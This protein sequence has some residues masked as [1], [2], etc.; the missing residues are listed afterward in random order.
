MKEKKFFLYGVLQ[1]RN[2]ALLL[3]F[4]TF[5]AGILTYNALPKQQYP[6]ISIP[7]A[8]ISAVYPGASAEDVEELVTKKIEDVAMEAD[9][10]DRVESFS[11]DNVSVVQ[12]FFQLDMPEDEQKQSKDDLRNKINDLKGTVLPADVSQLK[13]TSDIGDTAGLVLAFTSDK[14]SNEELYN[15]VDKLKTDLR[16]REGLKK[17]E[18]DG[19]A[20]QRIEIDVD[21]AKLNRLK[22]SL[23]ELSKLIPYQNNLLPAGKI[24]FNTDKI[25]VE[26]S[27]KFKDLDEIRN[28]IIGISPDTGN[29]VTLKDVATVEKTVDEDT[30]LYNYN[31]KNAILL[32]V[33]YADGINVVTTGKEVLEYIDQYK[34]KLPSDVKVNTVADLS[35]DVKASIWD[36]T[37]SVI[38]AILIV[39][40]VITL[41]MSLR[42]GTIVAVAI[43]ITMVVPFLVMKAMGIDVQFISLAALIIALGMV[44]D[45]V[46]VI[47]D[48]IQVQLDKDDSDRI[49]ACAEGV[50]GVAI[51]VL[52]S[53][54]STVC[55]FIS[56]YFMPGTTYLFTFSLPTIVISTML[57]SFV[58]SM[59]I[60]P[61][62]CFFM[63]K[64][65]VEREGK[66]SIMDRFRGVILAEYHLAAKHR[67]VT[68]AI[69]ICLVLG[70]FKLLGTLNIEFMPKGEK[71]ILDI[72]ITTTD[73]TDIRKTEKAV[74]DV[75]KVIMKQPESKYYLTSVGGSIPKYDFSILP[76]ADLTNSGNI[77][78]GFDLESGNNRFK[79][80]PHFVEYLQGVVDK[81]ISNSYVEVKQLGVVPESSTPIQL[82]LMGDDF[83]EL[84]DAAVKVENLMNNTE[85]IRNVYSDRQFKTLSYYVKMRQGT[86]NGYGLT[87]AEVQNE[88]NIALMGRKISVYRANNKEYPILLK[89]DIHSSNDLSNLM[90][91]STTTSAKHQ[92]GQVADIGTQE[93]YHSVTRHNGKRSIII[94]AYPKVGYS[95]VSLQSQVLKDIKTLGLG[96]DIGVDYSGDLSKMEEVGGPLAMGAL[97]GLMGIFILL[98][99]QYYSMRKVI[100]VLCSIPF[101]FVGA[102]IGLVVCKPGFNLFTILG[103]LSLMGIVINNTVILVECISELI[104]S[105]L[106]PSEAAAE[107]VN[108][109][110]RPILLGTMT[111]VLGMVPLALGGN[112]LFRG[113]AI[114]YMFGYGLSIFIT[115]VVIPILYNTVEDF[116]LRKHE[117]ARIRHL[118]KQE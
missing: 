7:V 111:S 88:I 13:Y 83:D 96:D 78:L 38:E 61:I 90:I 106:S 21:T 56:F 68:F 67:I 20:S 45:N 52:V 54:L 58:V 9:G 14:R 47:S 63:M 72:S 107:A 30:K 98:F 75:V 34:S 99:M 51:P 36:F 71:S 79:D 69:A 89:G 44:V 27:G 18:V 40:V 97:V 65:A 50:K 86:L 76:K 1:K 28:I 55:I 29:V 16:T 108:Q 12:V 49:R 8:V 118:K 11:Y 105:G 62:V 23:A 41:G 10:F 117:R 59:F 4:F 37:S 73:L 80:I 15:I 85:G 6:V 57:A 64:K 33:Y 87:K 91:K 112:A 24:K 17:V 77:I 60:T 31:G 110:F 66:K 114:A 70:A 92:I 26:T 25:P 19:E 53:T 116:I 115:L 5:V 48:A 3:A 84:N 74:N 101:G 109:R 100:M 103:L 104:E 22:V 93:I 42:N 113:L 94:S 32:D 43:P 81:S 102:S 35:T 39:L 46:V 82:R 95:A 2:I